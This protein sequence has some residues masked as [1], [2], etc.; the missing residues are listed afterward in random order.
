VFLDSQWYC[1]QCYPGAKSDK[2]GFGCTEPSTKANKMPA[3]GDPLKLELVS[4]IQL[5]VLKSMGL[6][7]VSLRGM[8]DIVEESLRLKEV[9]DLLSPVNS[10][11]CSSDWIKLFVD[12]SCRFVITSH[13][14][15][16]YRQFP[17]VRS[18]YAN[19]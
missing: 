14:A 15:R 11:S 2:K 18:F 5:A 4:A 16:L 12:T 17:R 6:N 13:P 19:A 1:R 8:G 3:T 10:A 9:L 7:V